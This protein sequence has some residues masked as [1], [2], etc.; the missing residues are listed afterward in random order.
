MVAFLAFFAVS[1]T[2]AL[3]GEETCG[4]FS[5]RVPIDP[6]WAAAIDL[7]AILA[8]WRW[9][10]SERPGLPAGAREQCAVAALVLLL[11]VG[12]PGGIVLAVSGPAVLGDDDEIDPNQ[13]AI[14]LEPEKWVGRRC[15][16]LPYIDIGDELSVGQWLVVLYHHDCTRCRDMV[17]AYEERALATA[18]DPA[19]PRVA[20]LAVPPH[21]TPLWRFA[22]HSSSRQGRLTASKEWFV[23][24]PAVLRLQDG[25]V[26][27]EPVQPWR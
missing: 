4:C 25:V 16:L 21:G 23:R 12:V 1:L 3:M 24:T 22:P 6:R 2:K 11:F 14:V 20:F 17:P 13:Q 19:E 27:P 15:P 8:L 9:H 10:P 7:A 18:S 26:Q 5:S